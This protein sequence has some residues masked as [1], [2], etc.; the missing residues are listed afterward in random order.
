MDIFLCELNNS[1]ATC[2]Y[3]VFMWD[4]TACALRTKEPGIEP[5]KKCPY[6]KKVKVQD[7]KEKM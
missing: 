4:Y 5:C 2:G 1:H 3:R 6:A 7:D